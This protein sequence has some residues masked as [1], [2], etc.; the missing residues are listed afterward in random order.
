MSPLPTSKPSGR[1]SSEKH[2]L[3]FSGSAG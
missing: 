3:L 1:T 2:C